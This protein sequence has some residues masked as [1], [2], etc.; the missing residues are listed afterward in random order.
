MTITIARG[1]ITHIRNDFDNIIIMVKDT[2]DPQLA[3]EALRSAAREMCDLDGWRS[4]YGLRPGTPSSPKY[5][6]DVLPTPSGPIVMI[7]G[8]YV[9]AKLLRTIPDVVAR[10]LEAVGISDATIASPKEGG[11]L[12][13][14]FSGI[15]PPRKALQLAL[16]TAPPRRWREVAAIPDEWLPEAAAWVTAG[17]G[18]DDLVD[19][20][21]IANEFSLTAGAVHGFLRQT[22]D[23]LTGGV[24]LINGEPTERYRG[25]SGEFAFSRLSLGAGGPAMT[26]DEL[27]ASFEA[28]VE[29][30]RRLAPSVG[31]AVVSV[32]PASGS[33]QHCNPSRELSS[34]WDMGVWGIIDEYVPD[35]YAYQV[36]GPR[37][38]ARLGGPPP[39]SSP[40]GGSRVELFV[41]QPAD[42]LIDLPDHPA[43]VV[44]GR[45]LPDIYQDA[46]RRNPAVRSS[47]YGLLAPCLVPEG[48]AQALVRERQGL[49]P[50]APAVGRTAPPQ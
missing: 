24:L 37:H 34:P 44:P 48:Q 13:N 14:V 42:W 22:R 21:V 19:A 47:A 17:L 28:L 33:F 12:T 43:Q 31:Y 23:A 20:A 50:A 9:P 8:G 29:V 36:L 4:A 32:D 7:D 40:L 10:H 3:T 5:V 45:R 49:P 26:D 11:K 46:F 1:V 16:F 35:A 38:L 30:A 27:L 15:T 6:S 39:G 25:V 18:D 41:G 2:P